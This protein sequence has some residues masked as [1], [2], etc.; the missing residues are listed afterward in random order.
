MA[1]RRPA[2]GTLTATAAP[3]LLLANCAI[4]APVQSAAPA[5]SPSAGHSEMMTLQNA[6]VGFATQTAEPPPGFV[7]VAEFRTREACLARGGSDARMV[8]F[9][10]AGDPAGLHTATYLQFECTE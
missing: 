6:Q 1:R 9:D 5:P 7:E 2:L 8:H 3:L 4:F 10:G